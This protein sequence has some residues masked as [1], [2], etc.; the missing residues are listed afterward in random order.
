VVDLLRHHGLAA[1]IAGLGLG[2][3]ARIVMRVI[4]WSAGLPG[5][6][7]SGGSLEVVVFGAL[8]GWPVGLT[9]Y[10][11]RHRIRS[12]L[13]WPGL[14][15]GG[16]LFLAFALVPPGSARS[17]LAGTP[18][19]PLLT[20]LLFLILFLLFGASLE[21]RWARWRRRRGPLTIDN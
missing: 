2:L 21:W 3:G 13:P 18:D 8:I 12:R 5:S 10:A 19:P 17:A 11:L 14:L 1:L 7:S 9:F 4:A 6:F 15:L 20:G 16:G